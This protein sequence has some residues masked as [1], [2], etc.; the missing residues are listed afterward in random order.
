MIEGVTMVDLRAAWRR[1][2]M[3]AGTVLCLWAFASPVQA[4]S[5]NISVV[6]PAFG[7]VDVLGGA[8]ATGYG[9]FAVTCSGAAK[10]VVQVC[11]SFGAGNGGAASDGS[12][13]YMTSGAG[14][15]RYN[16]YQD[17][18]MAT[19]W[20]SV[21]GDMGATSPP[22]VLVTLD[23]SGS[24]SANLPI[25][26]SVFGGQASSVAP[27][28]YAST[29][30]AN[31]RFAYY[32]GLGCQSVNTNA[33]TSTFLMTATYVPN[34]NVATSD[35]NF[36]SFAIMTAPVDGIGRVSVTC[37]AGS[38]YTIALSGGVANSTDPTQRHL[39]RGADLFIRYGLYRD[40]SHVLPWGSDLNTLNGGTGVGSAQQFNVF[41][42][43]PVQVLPP[44]GTYQ[45]T[46]IATVAY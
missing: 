16:I 17:A 11:P 34:C 33:S 37:S 28:N 35:L 29:I 24:G 10:Q 5:C 8:P 39:S 6:A 18:Q 12:A 15:L 22:S 32:S 21:F 23:L 19:I 46:I 13:R 36:G 25:N 3:L 38:S 41:G 7:S 4:Q 2:A 42:R 40:T 43:I 44:A 20:G 30:T 14:V 27:S 9:S 31:Y 26:A 1:L 45:D